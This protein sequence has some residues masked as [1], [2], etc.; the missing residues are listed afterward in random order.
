MSVSIFTWIESLLMNSCMRCQVVVFAYSKGLHES[1]SVSEGITAVNNALCA[2]R[3]YIL[4]QYNVTAGNVAEPLLTA[5]V[6]AQI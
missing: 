1:N 5:I 2:L 6:N 4:S 3:V